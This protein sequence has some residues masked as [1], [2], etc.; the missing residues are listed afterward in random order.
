MLQG[1]VVDAKFQQSCRDELHSRPLSSLDSQKRQR[2]GPNAATAADSVTVDAT[3]QS[4][5]DLER[6][7]GSR[8]SRFFAFIFSTSSLLYTTFTSVCMFTHA[9]CTYKHVQMWTNTKC[10]SITISLYC[11]VFNWKDSGLYWLYYRLYDYT[12][13]YTV[14]CILYF[15]DRL[16]TIGL[17]HTLVIVVHVHKVRFW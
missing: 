12:L 13:Y 2:V 14:Y 4:T 15:T 9:T 5:E 17:Y 8:G 16:R 1:Y 10:N 3:Q 6:L 11:I 7:A